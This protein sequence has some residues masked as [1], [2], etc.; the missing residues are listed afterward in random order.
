MIID[1]NDENFPPD[2]LWLPPAAMSSP[3]IQESLELSSG[4]FDDYCYVNKCFV[5]IILFLSSLLLIRSF[6]YQYEFE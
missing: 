6:Y 2:S 3:F 1:M 4:E 5:I